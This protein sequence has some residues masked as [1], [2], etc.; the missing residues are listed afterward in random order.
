MTTAKSITPRATHPTALCFHHRSVAAAWAA[1][2]GGLVSLRHSSSACF[3]H[4]SPLRPAMAATGSFSARSRA[5]RISGGTGT[6]PAGMLG[7]QART[8]SIRPAS[9]RYSTENPS[10]V[11][12]MLSRYPFEIHGVQS[13]P[14]IGHGIGQRLLHRLPTAEYVAW[15]KPM[16]TVVSMTVRCPAAASAHIA[17]TGVGPAARVSSSGEPVDE[18]ISVESHLPAPPTRQPS[19]LR[20]HLV[21]QARHQKHEQ[22]GHEQVRLPC[23]LHRLPPSTSG[24]FAPSERIPEERSCA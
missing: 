19:T 23:D 18:P 24:E 9:G 7:A 6:V 17:S 22:R 14:K 21:R 20:F 10:R 3:R 12:A 11:D 15:S 13:A 5:G 2:C 8:K 16:P 1:V 4:A